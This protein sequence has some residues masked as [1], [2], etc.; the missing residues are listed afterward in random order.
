MQALRYPLSVTV[1][2]LNILSKKA[3]WHS[4]CENLET[5]A[6]FI[7]SFKPKFIH[8]KTCSMLAMLE[9]H[10]PLGTFTKRNKILHQIPVLWLPDVTG[11]TSSKGLKSASTTAQLLLLAL[12]PKSVTP[13]KG[14]MAVLPKGWPRKY[15]R[16]QW[17]EQ[18][19]V[20]AVWKHCRLLLPSGQ[21]E[22]SSSED[23]H[24]TEAV[25]DACSLWLHLRADSPSNQVKEH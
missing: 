2:R 7:F 5:R 21:D 13:F 17:I 25:Q 20:L 18:L 14:K 22:A 9:N 19:P 16:L 23:T 8:F 4:A 1:L 6:Y 10:N 12:L 24:C 3:A 11:V 15:C